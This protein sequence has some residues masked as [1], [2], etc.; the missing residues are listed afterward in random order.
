MSG[1]ADTKQKQ[2]PISTRRPEAGYS[3]DWM[4]FDSSIHHDDV[5]G[6]SLTTPR[7]NAGTAGALAN[8]KK[9]YIAFHRIGLAAH[10][11]LGILA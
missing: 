8:G 6:L 2:K 1:R 4:H 11:E 10:T 3:M 7:T 5:C 9:V